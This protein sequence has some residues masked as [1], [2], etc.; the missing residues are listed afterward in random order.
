VA[1]VEHALCD[2]RE[3]DVAALRHQHWAPNRFDGAEVAY[4]KRLLQFALP[5]EL[6]AKLVDALFAKHVSA[7]EAAFAEELYV[8]VDE[9]QVMAANGMH[10]GSHGYEHDWLDKRSA[11]DQA[12]DITRSRELLAAVGVPRERFTFCYPYGSYDGNT[13]RILQSQGCELAVTTKP[14]RAR[15]GEDSLLELPRFDTNDLPKDRNAAP[16]QPPA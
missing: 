12:R 6:R 14:R 15:L 2:H 13:T 10:I 11:E 16:F 3:H 5:A 4:L 8:N 7:D 1:D 9:L